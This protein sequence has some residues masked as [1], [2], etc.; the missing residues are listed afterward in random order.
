MTTPSGTHYEN[1]YEFAK[2]FD[3]IGWS[4]VTV[5]CKA[6]GNNVEKYS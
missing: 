3:K 4:T 6:V 1:G 2:I 5:G